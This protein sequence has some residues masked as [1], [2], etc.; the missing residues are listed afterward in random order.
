MSNYIYFFSNLN[1]KEKE[2]KKAIEKMIEHNN[3]MKTQF[4]NYDELKQR[5]YNET[6]QDLEGN[7]EKDLDG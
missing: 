5:F 7:N 6:I 3:Q 2:Y 4:E 1:Q